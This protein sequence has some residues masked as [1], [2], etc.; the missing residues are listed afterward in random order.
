[1]SIYTV[2]SAKHIFFIIHRATLQMNLILYKMYLV[3]FFV[4]EESGFRI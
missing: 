3:C 2:H 1:M 4:V